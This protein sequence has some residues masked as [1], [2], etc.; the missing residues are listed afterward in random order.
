MDL[1]NIY[2]DTNKIPDLLQLTLISLG[3]GE[4]MEYSISNTQYYVLWV[5]NGSVKVITEKKAKR[6]RRLE[7]KTNTCLLKSAD[8]ENF[9]IKAG[10]QPAQ[11]ILIRCKI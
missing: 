10:D 7:D 5:I 9:I 6:T 11:L 8:G 1:Q 4:V 3:A 2:P